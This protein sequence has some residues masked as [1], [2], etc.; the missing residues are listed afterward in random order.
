MCI[1]FSHQ[2]NSLVLQEGRDGCDAVEWVAEQSW[3]T[4]KVGMAGNSWLTIAQW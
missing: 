1:Q 4:G 3:C 2:L